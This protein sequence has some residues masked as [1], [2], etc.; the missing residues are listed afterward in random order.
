MATA[1]NISLIFHLAEKVKTV[2]DAESDKY[3]EVWAKRER[4]LSQLTHCSQNVYALSDLSQRMIQLY[5]KARS[6]TLTNI[7]SGKTKLPSDIFHPLP[8]AATANK[9]C[10]TTFSV[11]F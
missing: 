1:D 6:W 4:S 9:V 10:E 5:A 11:N 7:P 3:N 8:D 2:R